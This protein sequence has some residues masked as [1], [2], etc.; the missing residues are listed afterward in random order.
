MVYVWFTK[1]CVYSEYQNRTEQ[2]FY[3]RTYT[4]YIVT[5]QY[6]YICHVWYML[7][8][9]NSYACL[10]D[11]ISVCIFFKE[12]NKTRT[13]T[14][15]YTHIHAHTTITYTLSLTYTHVR[16]YAR[17]HTHT[18]TRQHHTISLSHIHTR[19]HACTRAHTNTHT[20]TYLIQVYMFSF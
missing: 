3:F 6:I 20:H 14:H 8:S 12:N 17:T 10:R 5:L 16:T 11:N 19:T 15:A 9:D 18:H 7:H 2:I 4:K 1:D 13:R